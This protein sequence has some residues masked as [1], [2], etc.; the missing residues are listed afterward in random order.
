MSAKSQEKIGHLKKN[1]QI[2]KKN[3]YHT[4]THQNIQIHLFQGSFLNFLLSLPLR[5]TDSDATEPSAWAGPPAPSRCDSAA[6]A[7]SRPRRHRGV[8]RVA[9]PQRTAAARSDSAGGRGE[10]RSQGSGGEEGWPATRRGR[11][12]HS[13][14]SSCSCR[15]W[16]CGC[17]AGE[18]ARGKWEGRET[19]GGR[20]EGGELGKGRQ[21]GGS[22]SWVGAGGGSCGEPGRKQ[23]V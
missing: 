11:K 6:H 1:P 20:E 23:S 18:R 2:L 17:K 19:G 14:K 9:S 21:W 12:V 5:A 15:T 22:S 3:E 13:R 10:G 4:D 7:T 16:W 8:R